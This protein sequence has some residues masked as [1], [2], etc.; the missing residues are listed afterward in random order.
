LCFLSFAWTL[1]KTC[2]V[3]L[4]VND[5]PQHYISLIKCCIHKLTKIFNHFW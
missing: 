2:E 3:P 4:C 5:I 1:G